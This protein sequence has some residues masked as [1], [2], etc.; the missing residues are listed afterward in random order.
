MR[1]FFVYYLFFSLFAF[2]SSAATNP[3][4][5]SGKHDTK[6]PIE[7]TSDQLDVLQEENK[8]IFTGQVVAIQGDVR[9]KSDKMTVYYAKKDE[10]ASTA[11]KSANPDEAGAIKKIDV[12]GNV[13]LKTAQETASGSK[14]VYD[15]E[16]QLITLDNN[17]VLTRDKN[18]LKGDHLVYN[19]ASGKST[20]SSGVSS[21]IKDGLGKQRVRALFVPEKTDEKK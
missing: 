15:V 14:G 7:I 12:D 19:F 10:N 1:R 6:Q 16:K 4:S 3:L 5:G 17:V 13:F 8:A 21:V 11:K 2:A 18:T 9:L 20:L